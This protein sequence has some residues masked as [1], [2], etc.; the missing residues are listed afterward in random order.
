M[1][2]MLHHSQLLLGGQ[3]QSPSNGLSLALPIPPLWLSRP[4]FPWSIPPGWSGNLLHL[5]EHYY[6]QLFDLTFSYSFRCEIIQAA[7]RALIKDII[8][9]A[10]SRRLLEHRSPASPAE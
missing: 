1:W 9:Q 2:G 5:P 10:L 6:L 4:R 3:S 8:D 7:S